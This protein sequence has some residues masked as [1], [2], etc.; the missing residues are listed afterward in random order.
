V[1]HDAHGAG[2]LV[3]AFEADER[4]VRNRHRPGA[5]LREVDQSGIVDYQSRPSDKRT[6]FTD[7]DG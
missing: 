7:F 5:C 6:V 3:C 2:T 4:I 1:H